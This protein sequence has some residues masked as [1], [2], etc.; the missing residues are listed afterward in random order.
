MRLLLGTAP[1]RLRRGM[2]NSVDGLMAPVRRMLS[3]LL[4]SQAL[5]RGDI[6]AALL[7]LTEAAAAALRVER[8]SVWHFDGNRSHLVCLDLFEKGPSRH[9]AGMVLAAAQTPQYFA[10]LETERSIAAHDART[11]P[12]T[13]EFTA[14]YLDP[15][16]ITSMLD[17]P[18]ILSGGLS[19]VVC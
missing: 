1:V 11:D 4:R 2:D 5:E 19:G 15:N 7:Q 17:A 18:V 8:A 6:D 16:R 12:R 10:A 9:S 3:A 13:R 14:S